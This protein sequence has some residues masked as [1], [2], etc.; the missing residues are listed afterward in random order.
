MA[1]KLTNELYRVISKV[2][3][4]KAQ[5]DKFTRRISQG[6]LTRDE[7]PRSHFCVYFAGFDPNT[8]ELYLGLHKKSGLWLFN[9]GHI[10]RGET[11]E[12]AL[13]REIT[14]EWSNQVAMKLPLRPEMI[15]L[16][17]IL[18]P[19]KQPCDW[20]YD[21]WYLIF[22]DKNKAKFDQA[23]LLTEFSESEWMDSQEAKK[24]VIDPCTLEAIAY[25]E[26]TYLST[27]GFSI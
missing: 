20:H 21:I 12:V 4:S 11:L 16:T 18:K 8:K 19:S 24:L 3:L 1:D 14:E 17:K 9:G 7:N 15:T 27:P 13:R 6:S 5:I 23:K 2:N 25:L 26:N 22:L 10:D